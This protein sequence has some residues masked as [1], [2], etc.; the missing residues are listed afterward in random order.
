MIYERRIGLNLG[1]FDTNEFIRNLKKTLTNSER[2]AIPFII[3]G[4]GILDTLREERPDIAA[5]VDSPSEKVKNAV[6]EIENRF[7]TMWKKINNAT[8]GKDIG[9]ID[10]YI[11]HIWDLNE[12]TTEMQTKYN[13][14]RNRYL[15]QRIVSSIKEGME[16]GLVPKTLDVADIMQIYEKHANDVIYNTKF[17]KFLEELNIDGEPVLM[18]ADVAPNWYVRIENIALEKYKVHPDVAQSVRIVFGNDKINDKTLEKIVSSVEV[19]NGLAKKMNLSLSLFH[20]GAL[21][22]TAIASSG[23]KSAKTIFYDIPKAG[24]KSTH[25]AFINP[26]LTRDAILHGV[27]L[28]ATSDIPVKEIANNTAKIRKYLKDKNIHVAKELAALLDVANSAWDRALWDYLH[29]GFKI[30][31]YEQ[32]ALKVRERGLKKGWNE[33]TIEKQLREVGQLIND[34]YGGQNWD[35]LGV[36]PMQLRLMRFGLLSPDWLVSSIRQALAPFGIG[37]LYNDLPENT[38]TRMGIKFWVNAAIAFGVGMNA[39]N[40]IFRKRDEEEQKRLIEEENI[41]ILA[42]NAVRKKKGLPSLPLRKNPYDE[43]EL[44]HW[45]DYTFYGNTIGHKTHLFIGRYDDGREKY[46]RWRKQFRE[47]PELLFDNEGFSIPYPALKKIAQKSSPIINGFMQ[48]MPSATTLSGF[49]NKELKEAKGWRKS[50][51]A[52]KTVLKMFLP[53]SVS[54]TRPDKELTPTDFVMPSSTGMSNWKA[55]NLF[56]KGIK[57]EDYEYVRDVYTGSQRNGL[58]AV[59]LLKTAAKRVDSEKAKRIV[60]ELE[61]IIEIE[62]AINEYDLKGDEAKKNGV[63]DENN[64]YYKIAD[65]IYNRYVRELDIKHIEFETTF[66]DVLKDLEDSGIIDRKYKIKK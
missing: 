52:G 17:I 57:N 58:N 32:M 36:T 65:R 4:K 5:I 6:S 25:P 19:V 2:E 44:K 3:E 8:D 66:E 62:N 23:F 28:G 9:F 61:S 18:K 48:L 14:T 46:L 38:R 1:G 15:K 42:Q 7:D 30:Y 31:G 11:T 12:S 16:L 60:K 13:A 20:H 33:I 53:Y 24:L 45:Y 29:D 39:L 59:D 27:Q 64:E 56:M 50:Y 40:Y 47:L 63:K 41:K 22:E 37:K 51:E 43:G 54:Q 10:E 21:T 34:V 26:E 35:V 49:E 55:I